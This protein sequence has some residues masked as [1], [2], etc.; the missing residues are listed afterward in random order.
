M[1]NLDSNL[2]TEMVAV[3]VVIMLC[4]GV[5]LLFRHES[6]GGRSLFSELLMSQS[7]DEIGK[8]VSVPPLLPSCREDSFSRFENTQDHGVAV[9]SRSMRLTPLSQTKKV[10]MEPLLE[11]FRELQDE[12]NTGQTESSPPSSGQLAQKSTAS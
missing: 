8:P 3:S 2:E 9:L 6:H 12:K 11:S 10:S 5:W 7:D 4:M 1:L